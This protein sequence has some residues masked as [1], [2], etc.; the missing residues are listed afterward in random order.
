AYSDSAC[1]RGRARVEHEAHEGFWLRGVLPRAWTENPEPIAMGRWMSA[2]QEG[3]IAAGALGASTAARPPV[4]FGGATGGPEAAA[5]ALRQVG[6]A[7]VVVQPH[8]GRAVRAI[9]GG[10]SGPQQTVHR[11]EQ[12]ALVLAAQCS[13]GPTMFISDDL[14]VRDGWWAQ[15]DTAPRGPDADAWR[16]LAAVFADRPLGA[17]VVFHVNSQVDEADQ[18]RTPQWAI[19]PWQRCLPLFL[20]AFIA[21]N[22][23]PST[24]AGS[25]SGATRGAM[26]AEGKAPRPPA[27]QRRAPPGRRAAALLCSSHALAADGSCSRCR[28]SASRAARVEWLQTP[29]PGLHNVGPD[30]CELGGGQR[31]RVGV[32]EPHGSHTM[33][34]HT[35]LDLWYCRCRGFF[36][37]ASRQQ[38]ERGLRDECPARG[39]VRPT[40][41]GKF[42]LGRILRGLWPKALTRAV[43]ARAAAAAEA[44]AATPTVPGAELAGPPGVSSSPRA[45]APARFCPHA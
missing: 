31:V 6:L 12:G 20:I 9:F 21:P 30:L 33:A 39:G 15:R 19:Y 38:F 17:S 29:C 42:Y 32:G 5:P 14:S 37:P 26:A 10:L 1:Q 23:V 27:V 41:T 7:A 24:F 8:D 11:G 35:A 2:G 36:A 22:A 13:S 3:P 40:T 18:R 44:A 28:C 4:V 34:L 16:V 45:E 25:F 43:A